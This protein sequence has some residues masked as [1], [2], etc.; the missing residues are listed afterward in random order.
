LEHSKVVFGI[1]TATKATNNKPLRLGE[2]AD[3]AP[4]VES[5]FVRHEP[6]PLAAIKAKRGTARESG[7]GIDIMEFTSNLFGVS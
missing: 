3:N 7:C 2:M 5:V 4:R 6:L 1:I